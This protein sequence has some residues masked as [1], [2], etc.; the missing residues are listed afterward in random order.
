MNCSKIKREVLP[1]TTTFRTLC[2]CVYVETVDDVETWDI[3]NVCDWLLWLNPNWRHVE[4]EFEEFGVDGVMLL[5]LDEDEL[6]QLGAEDDAIRLTIS[7]EIEQMRSRQ[8]KLETDKAKK[9]EEDYDDVPVWERVC[10][11]RSL[12]MN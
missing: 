10:F 6:R 9:L 5:T 7:Q 11:F 8:D 2:T 3:D 4:M 1:D 12:K